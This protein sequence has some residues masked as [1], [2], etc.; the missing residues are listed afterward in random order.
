MLKEYTQ[1]TKSRFERKFTISRLSKQEIELVIKQNSALFS[2]IFH[3]R[4]INN[5]YLDTPNLTFFFDNNIGKSNRKKIRIRWYGDMFGIISH[6]IL[7]FKIKTGAA[8]RKLSFPLKS[9]N[10]D[11]N[12]SIDS[13]KQVFHNSNLPLW[14]LNQLNVLEPTLANRYKRKYFRSFDKNFRI[15]IDSDITYANITSRINT[16]A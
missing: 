6:P 4:Y 14:V 15:T 10:F 12:F 16:F 2:E 1:Q 11:K 13:L 8:G 9:F 3:Q 7:E 5:I